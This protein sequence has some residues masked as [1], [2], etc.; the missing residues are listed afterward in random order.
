MST[1]SFLQKLRTS[2]LLDKDA[3]KGV[4]QRCQA[5]GM[6][7]D[8]DV[9]RQLV[10]DGV[11][12]RYQAERL[13]AGRT[14]GFVL[15]PY[16]ILDRL[17]AGGMG[18]V[19]KAMHRDMDRVV[20]I[21]VLPKSRRSS[22][23]AQARFM[24]E[25]RAS[26][27]LDHPNIA[28]AYD[29]GRQGDVTYLVMQYVDGQDLYR[30]LRERGR[31]GAQEAADIGCQTAKALEHA[32]GQGIVHRDIKPPN[33]VIDRQGT[34]LV[35]DMGLARIRRDTIDKPEQA[36]GAK[37]SEPLTADGQVMGTTDYMAPEQA[38]DSHSADIRA[39]IYSLGCTL[40]HLL[41]GKPPFPGGELAEK[42]LR[43]QLHQA[44]PITELAPDVPQG[45]AAIV[46]KMMA[47]SPDDRQQTPT[48][49][50]EDLSP[51]TE[52]STT[53]RQA[54]VG[55]N[56]TT[57][58]PTP[59]P[60]AV[61]A[62]P[63][64][65]GGAHTKM[66]I[67]GAAAIAVVAALAIALL[68]PRASEPTVAHQRPAAPKAPEPEPAAPKEPE[69]AAPRP[70]PPT[71]LA[72]SLRPE[73]RE[74]GE[75]YD[76]INA[77]WADG[78][79]EQVAELL[80]AKAFAAI[81]HTDNRITVVDRD[82]CRQMFVTAASDLRA[83]RVEGLKVMHYGQAAFCEMRSVSELEDGSTRTDRV[84]D[85]LVKTD[86]GWRCVLT[87]PAIVHLVDGLEVEEVMADGQAK[88]VGLRVGDVLTHYAGA[89]LEQVSD[90]Q[91]MSRATNVTRTVPLV[92]QRPGRGVASNAGGRKHVVK[93]KGRTMTH[94]VRGG[95][96]GVKVHNR[97]VV[98]ARAT[99]LSPEL[100]PVVELLRRYAD[101]VRQG[102]VQNTTHVLHPK[103]FVDMRIGRDGRLGLRDRQEQI[104]FLTEVVSRQQR[105]SRQS[106][107]FGT[108]NLA[109][110]DR[111]ALADTL[112]RF[113]GTNGNSATS[114]YLHVLVKDPK[115]RLVANLP[116]ILSL[117]P[118]S[119]P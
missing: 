91:K 59:A 90:L 92:V 69:P 112:Y 110:A 71:T 97:A 23:Q 21:K 5:Q 93:P 37:D 100:E 48:Q 41:T 119:S 47:K 64:A 46:E 81:M 95:A 72:A 13:L 66:W 57:M 55:P 108:I 16:V 114:R 39:D 62:L 107:K 32:H 27:K 33:I 106:F 29:V 25:V 36:P 105:R 30:L 99:L 8:R 70:A 102:R 111:L 96:L 60:S 84:M 63:T 44:P 77:C 117:R 61:S 74:I 18:Q 40:Y 42:L 24:R 34:A 75:L 26:A 116:G 94:Y 88:L 7:T 11:L 65:T 83:H 9:A 3:V 89:P 113:T 85:V 73:Q 78:K 38:L 45:L 118:R 14:Q 109:N 50:L 80:H 49:V 56:A 98:D 12:T 22:A 6:D 53:G 1:D 67:T 104:D 58:A 20:A 68:W 43:H 52:A 51:W 115:W 15:G 35:L 87:M 2:Q 76:R 19:F 86:A 101:T 79:P 17:G 10:S 4:A 103:A 31:L 82:E 28:T 54:P